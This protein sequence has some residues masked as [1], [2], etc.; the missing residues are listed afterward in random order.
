MYCVHFIN[1]VIF[2]S[3]HLSDYSLPI[4]ILNTEYYFFFFYKR[5]TLTL[6]VFGQTKKTVIYYGFIIFEVILTKLQSIVVWHIVED[7]GNL[8]SKHKR[9][10]NVRRD[11]SV[12][13]NYFI[14]R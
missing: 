11:M 12:F 7:V 8:L 6:I 3:I 10:Y 9:L 4:E 13:K 2:P 1:Y 5:Q 14:F